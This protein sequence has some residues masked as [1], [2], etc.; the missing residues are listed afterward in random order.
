MCIICVEIVKGLLT[1]NEINAAYREVK[2]SLNPQH[3][4]DVEDAVKNYVP[5][6]KKD[7]VK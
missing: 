4:K 3:N 6:P 5:K 7:K 1:N 2:E